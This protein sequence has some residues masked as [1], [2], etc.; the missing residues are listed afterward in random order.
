M[1]RLTLYPDTAPEQ[2]IV[3]L[4]DPSEIAAELARVGVDF[5]RWQA[6]VALPSDASQDEILAAYARDIARLQAQG[7][8]VTRDVVRLKPDHPDR[9]ALRQKF[10]DEHTH[11]EDEVRF[12]CRRQRRVLSAFK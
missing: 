3:S 10:L 5:E 1:S 4:T 2:I 6:D 11:S 8:Y 12:F 9:A 7:G